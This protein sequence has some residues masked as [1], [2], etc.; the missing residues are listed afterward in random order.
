MSRAINGYARALLGLPVKDCSG[1]FRCYR[2]SKLA[3]L[4]F[5]QIRSRGYSYLEE[6][7]WLLKRRGASFGETPIVFVDRVAGQTKI[8]WREAVAALLLISGIGV[9]NLLGD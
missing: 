4:D 6:I 1:A 8:N 2:C 9:K 7:L 3:E 5:E